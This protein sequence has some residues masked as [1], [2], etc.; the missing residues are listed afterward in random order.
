MSVKIGVLGMSKSYP[1]LDQH[2]KWT[3]SNN[4]VLYRFFQKHVSGKTL[5]LCCG[6]SR[7]N[8]AINFDIGRYAAVDVQGD[9]FKLPFRSNCFDTVLSDPPYKLAY[10][11]RPFWVQ[12]ILRVIKKRKGSKIVL[13]LDFIPYLKD[14]GLKELY[15]YQGARYWARV[16]LLLVFEYMYR[17][18]PIPLEDFINPQI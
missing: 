9:M 5:H 16:S 15:V 12:E 6:R 10:D 11:M 2:P 1:L 13:K 14:F 7:L 8:G 17:S 3:F 18:E 4:R